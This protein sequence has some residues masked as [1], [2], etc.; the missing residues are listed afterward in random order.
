MS[1]KGYEFSDRTKY[2]AKKRWHTKNPGRENEE[3]EVHHLLPVSEGKKRGVPRD[4][5]RSDE[6]AIA[7]PKDFHQEIH[8]ELDE[9]TI[10][11]LVSYFKNLW[12]QLF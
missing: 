9:S 10:L 3:L 6:N 4:A 8:R 11:Y 5:L 1:R 12:K 2:Q 7:V